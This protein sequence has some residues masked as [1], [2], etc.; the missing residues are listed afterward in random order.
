MRR[1][2][3]ILFLILASY[4]SFAGKIS[5]N[6][7]DDK[8]QPLPYSSILVKGTSKGTTAN[9]EGKYLLNLDPGSYTIVCQHVGY[10]REEKTI[11]VGDETVVLNFQLHV[12]EL[13][14]KEVIVKKGEDPAY[15]II[16]H[17]IKKRS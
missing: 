3:L 14:M 5:G 15:E 17:A 9:G 2:S 7:T 11:T 10:S 13:T 12:Q 4:F 6:I 1:S 8:G 16:R